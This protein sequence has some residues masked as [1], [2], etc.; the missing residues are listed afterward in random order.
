ME[1][2]IIALLILLNGVFS[3]SEIALVSSRKFK[4]EAAAKKGSKNAQR[5]LNLSNNPNTF[6]STVQIGITLIGILTG[7]YSGDKI[8]DDL[9]LMVD[10]IEQ[11]RPY[12]DT[13]A[14]GMVVIIITYFSIVFGELIPKRIGLIFPET[15]ASLV[16]GPMK[17][18]SIITKPFIWLLGITNDFFFR[19]FGIKTQ[20][21]GIVSEEEIKS[22]V[23][24]SAEKGEILEI[25]QEIVRRVF[26][27]GDRKVRELMTHRSEI[28]WLDVDDTFENIKRRTENEI[29]SVYPVANKELDK[30]EGLVHIKDLFLKDMVSSDFSLKN[31]LRK[32]LYISENSPA[33]KLF[34][35]F[36]KSQ[37]HHAIVLDEYGS[38]EGLI[39]FNDILDSLVG[40]Y[41][42]TNDSEYK[43][44]KRDENSWLADGQYSFHEFTNYF[45]LEN[46]DERDFNT[47]GGLIL[48]KLNH[49][50][51]E[52]EKIVWRE[53]EMEVVDMD[54]R[55]IDKILISKLPEDD[56]LI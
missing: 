12:S 47:L 28:V 33:Y 14:V 55:R 50:P 3:M 11:L 41:V 21:D 26:A 45:K 16:S 5:A 32:P 15:I 43:I 8:T 4:L 53:F 46:T 7:I 35:E 27:L 22:I 24:E 17:V 30:L 40:D 6:L 9:K 23:Q 48:D 36:K 13:I 31:H 29:H 54:E 38:I 52:G 49:I 1:I 34:E 25:E 20:M 2:L 51:V 42:D 10:N 19:I 44:V 37:V 39:S 18:I 56:Y